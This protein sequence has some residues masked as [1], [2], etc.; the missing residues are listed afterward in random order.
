MITDQQFAGVAA[1]LN[2]EV[3]AIKAVNKVESNGNGFMAN[4]KPKILFEGHVFW[5]QLLALHMN[6]TALQKGNEDV[7][8]PTW[9]PDI[10]RPLYKLDQYARLAKA[11]KINR[12]A[13][14]NSASWGAFQI[15]GFNFRACGYA[16]VKSF[17]DAMSDELSQ[18]S[19]FAAYLKSTHID[20]HL[21]HLDWKGFARAY[22]GPDYAKNQYDTKLQNA[23]NSF[24]PVTA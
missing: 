14:L 22:N 23:Y 5:K 16:D 19:A 24:K 9:N 6:P 10:V 20:V 3:A 2:C 18:L 4:G 21:Q 13:A 1:T 8:Y 12:D 7:L 17:T 15:M 11:E